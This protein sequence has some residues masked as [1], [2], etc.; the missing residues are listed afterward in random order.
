M[1]NRKNNFDF[2]R[3]IFASFVIVTHSYPLSG[4]T[5]SDFLFHLSNGQVSL[6]YV[7]V[8]GFFVISGYLIFQSLERS[9]NILEYFRKRLLR[10]FPALFVVL[11]LT[12]ILAP[13]V[14]EG[15]I[16][17]FQNKSVI[18]YIPNNLILYKNQYEI[19]GIFEKNP[20][21]SAINGSLWTLPYEFTMYI[22]LSTLIIFRNNTRTTQKLLL[23][24]FLFLLIVDI[25]FL[26][27]LKQYRYLS[28]FLELSVYFSAGSLMAASSFEK[29][30][31]KKTLLIL[32]SMLAIISIYFNFFNYV[33][34]VALPTIIIFVGLSPISFICNIKHKIG[35][36]SYG[37]YIYGFPVQ[38]TLMYYFKFNYLY[39]MTYSLIISYIL[40]FFSWHFVE[41]QAL[42]FKQKRKSTLVL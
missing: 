24:S 16:P 12:V 21:K 8:R 1:D 20:Y 15:N 4:N 10:I 3:L 18:T 22:L 6:S 28:H 36:L 33:K 26:K 34:Y 29:V 2:L 35:D 17:F 42:K 14:Y 11:L 30:N 25:F 23:I 27:Q 41:K 31:S 9:H 38:Q 39:L 32:I 40:A 37:I 7:G 13:F 19:V 5:K